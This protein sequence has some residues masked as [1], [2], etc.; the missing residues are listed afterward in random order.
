MS[1]LRAPI[2]LRMPISRVRSR[3]DTSMMFMIPMPPTMSEIE[4]MPAEHERQR[5]AHRRDGLEQ[6]RLV[7]DLEVVILGGREPVPLRAAASVIA[8][9]A[10]SISGSERALT[11]IVRTASRAREVLLQRRDRDEDLVV[12]VLEA[13]RRPS[14]GG[15]RRRRRAARR[16]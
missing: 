15:C 9:L 10:A 4:A 7:E 13:R 2:A 11:A 8:A 6:L 16:S 12:G 1:R 3:T 14:P 5:A